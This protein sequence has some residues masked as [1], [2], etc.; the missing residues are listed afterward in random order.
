MGST[1]RNRGPWVLTSLPKAYVTR[2][3]LLHPDREIGGG[4]SH[5]W[6]R[7]LIYDGKIILTSEN[8]RRILNE[9]KRRYKMKSITNAATEKKCSDQAVRNACRRGDIT[10]ERVGNQYVIIENDLFRAWAPR[11]YGAYRA[12]VNDSA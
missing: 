4:F 11:P 10:Y 1:P 2:R 8:N 5:M 7:A 6:K 9:R 3:G 12:P